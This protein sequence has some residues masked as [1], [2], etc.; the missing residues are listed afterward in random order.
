MPKLRH[1]LFTLALAG[2]AST[3]AVRGTAQQA[4]PQGPVRHLCGGGNPLRHRTLDG[5]ILVVAL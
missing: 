4:R 5:A 1:A 2:V 3:L